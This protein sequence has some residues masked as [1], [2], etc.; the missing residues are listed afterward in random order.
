MTAGMEA[1]QAEQFDL[2]QRCAQADER[3]GHAVSM[4][5]RREVEILGR[6][7]VLIELL[8]MSPSNFEDLDV[9]LGGLHELA[10]LA[11]S[12]Q[13]G[14]FD[15]V[16][17]EQDGL[18]G[19][20]TLS[21][22]LSS[23]DTVDDMLD[24]ISQ[25]PRKGRHDSVG[26][27]PVSQA[28]TTTATTKEA[29]PADPIL[30]TRAPGLDL[31]NCQS[32][33]GVA[34][35]TLHTLPDSRDRKTVDPHQKP[36]RKANRNINGSLNDRSTAQQIQTTTPEGQINQTTVELSMVTTT[37]SAY[38]QKTIQNPAATPIRKS[39]SRAKSSAIVSQFG[40]PYAQG[41]SRSS[42][43]GNTNDLFP[44]TPVPSSRDLFDPNVRLEA[45]QHVFTKTR[46][47]KSSYGH[48]QQNP[49]VSLGIG[50]VSS[51][52]R[53]GANS[54]KPRS[55]NQPAD[56]SSAIGHVSR[57]LRNAGTSHASGIDGARRRSTIRTEPAGTQ[58]DQ[59]DDRPRPQEEVRNSIVPKSVLKDTTSRKRTAAT[60]GLNPIQRPTASLREISQLGPILPDTQS[61]SQG[62][63]AR[64][65]GNK[66]RKIK[67]PGMVVWSPTLKYAHPIG[68]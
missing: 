26:T 47:L 10:T 21:S 17:A 66:R 7:N 33:D 12:I 15:R 58:P 14:V 18:H 35:G 61:P 68:R 46:G 50:T 44:P 3:L 24:S 49:V 54:A 67:G 48:K 34:A 29:V 2:E 63:R 57:S 36:R 13:K 30:P 65:G 64:A 20:Q 43:L 56:G 41:A 9:A 5:Q 22:P 32:G 25:S 16:A 62:A 1:H 59:G 60:A 19:P 40:P 39:H 11:G 23:L 6:V 4:A 42:P 31:R 38:G 28:K 55:H 27:R 51:S 8:K 37:T 45:Q 53:Q 52:H